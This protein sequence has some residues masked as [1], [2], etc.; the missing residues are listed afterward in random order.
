MVLEL[1]DDVVPDGL[2]SLAVFAHFL[3]N[4]G[5]HVAVKMPALH[6]RHVSPL[7]WHREAHWDDLPGVVVLRVPQVF[8]WAQGRQHSIVVDHVQIKLG[9][10]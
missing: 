3:H 5:V 10:F 8:V 2:E 1:H 4:A 9:A 6:V 7:Y